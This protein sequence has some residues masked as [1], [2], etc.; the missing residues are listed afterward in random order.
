MSPADRFRALTCTANL[1]ANLAT[2]SVRATFF[3]AASGFADF[4][5]RLGSTAILARLITPDHFG[6]VM[7]ASAVIA[8]ADQLRELGL[9]SATVQQP[10]LT[11][12]QVSNLF[13]IN[14]GVGA[15]LAL[16]LCAASPAIAAYYHDPRLIP[17]ACLLASTLL[18]GGLTVQHQALLTRQLKLGHTAAVRLASSVLSTVLCVALAYWDFGYWSLLWREVARAAFLAAGMWL[19]FPWIPG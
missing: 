1:R 14:L 9:S 17:I 12:E 18:A 11:H 15:V 10:N 16:T 19:C 7:M 3:T 4:A 5:V 2:R 6:L 8:V 13:W